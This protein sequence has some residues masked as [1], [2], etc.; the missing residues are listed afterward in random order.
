MLITQ[1]LLYGEKE[2]IHS[3]ILMKQIIILNII[4]E[5]NGKQFNYPLAAIKQLKT[6]IHEYPLGLCVTIFQ[7]DQMVACASH[8]LTNIESQYSQIKCEFLSNK[9]FYLFIKIPY[10]HS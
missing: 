3:L 4:M 5:V 1:L 9:S 6:L 8:K 7:D 10:F 2:Q